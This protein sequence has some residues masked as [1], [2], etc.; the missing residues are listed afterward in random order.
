MVEHTTEVT[1]LL[2]EWKPHTSG[3]S[4]VVREGTVFFLLYFGSLSLKT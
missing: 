1:E 4:M 2:E 3:V